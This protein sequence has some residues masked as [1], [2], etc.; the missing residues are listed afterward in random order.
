MHCLVSSCR[1]Y[2]ISVLQRREPRLKER[3]CLSGGDPGS[4]QLVLE[5][6]LVA[7]KFALLFMTSMRF[8][9]SMVSGILN[10]G[11]PFKVPGIPM[12]R[13]IPDQLNHSLGMDSSK[14]LGSKTCLLFY[15]EPQPDLELQRELDGR[16]REEIYL[17]LL[18]LPSS[19]I[20]SL[21]SH[22]RDWPPV[23]LLS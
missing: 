20:S 13:P 11:R 21:S 9:F 8:S 15:Q 4:K 19:S 5:T 1:R 10:R 7:L 16:R 2:L 3:K 6:G 23:S 14:N 18:P 12:A 17:I 22:S